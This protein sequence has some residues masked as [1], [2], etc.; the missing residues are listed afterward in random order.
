MSAKQSQATPNNIPKPSK[1]EA[2]REHL[3]ET[4]LRELAEHGYE[5]LRLRDVAQRA[6]LTTGSVYYHFK[7]K[8]ELVRAVLE[9]FTAQ[10]IAE[11]TV[12][13]DDT[14]TALE[15]LRVGVQSLASV[16][17]HDDWRTSFGRAIQGL[18]NRPELHHGGGF[19]LG[20]RIRQPLLEAFENGELVLPE[21]VSREAA[22]EIVFAA[23]FGVL[24]MAA[25]GQAQVPPERAVMLTLEWVLAGL[26]PR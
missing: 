2:T 20:A 5:A 8:D 17:Q 19:G 15:R 18:L 26:K 16:I 24:N 3:L 11:D 1:R 12:P 25:Q 10:A 21:G 7:D 14:L 4:A 13:P 9:R 22:S 6:G 23:L